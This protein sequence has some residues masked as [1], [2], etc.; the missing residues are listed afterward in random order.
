MSGKQSALAK[1]AAT[2]GKRRQ[3]YQ[4][5]KTQTAEH[6]GGAKILNAPDLAM[7]FGRDVISEFFDSSVEEFYGQYHEQSAYHSRIPGGAR[8]DNEAEQHAQDDEEAFVA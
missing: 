7:L 8:G 6:G 5:G 4:S 3:P 1:Q 2:H